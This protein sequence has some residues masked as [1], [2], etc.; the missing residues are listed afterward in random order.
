MTSKINARS[1]SLRETPKVIRQ[2]LSRSQLAYIDLYLLHDAV[3]GP[4]RRLEAWSCL[5]D[6]KKKG[7]VRMVGVS[8]WNVKHLEELK[9]KGWEMPRVNQIELHPW[10]QQVSRHVF[11]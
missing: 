7:L 1:H 9:E 11:R 2:S 6:A 10:C 4:V 5:L 3:S 8:N